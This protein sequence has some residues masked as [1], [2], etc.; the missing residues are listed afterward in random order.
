MFVSCLM[1][2]DC[3]AAETMRT[4]FNMLRIIIVGQGIDGPQRSSLISA[5]QSHF[6]CSVIDGRYCVWRRK[7]ERYTRSCG[8]EFG[9]WSD[10]N[11]M[12]LAESSC[13]FRAL[14]VFLD[15]N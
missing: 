4:I 9:R 15:W 7:G 10:P 8:I 1:H 12:V 13:N 6:C 14:L 11:M 5:T 3:R 2:D